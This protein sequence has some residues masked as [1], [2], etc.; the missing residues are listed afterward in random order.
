MSTKHNKLQISIDNFIFTIISYNP[1]AY[2]GRGL[3]LL[4][5][6]NT[7]TNKKN[8]L[9]LYRSN[10]DL[11]FWRLCYTKDSSDTSQFEKGSPRKLHYVMT[12]F[13]HI[14]LQIFINKKMEEGIIPINDEVADCFT[15]YSSVDGLN[16]KIYN[17]I[18]DRTGINVDYEDMGIFTND[19]FNDYFHLQERNNNTNEV[20]RRKDEYLYN[21][22]KGPFTREY[23][24]CG[25]NSYFI[26]KEII[27][28]SNFLEHNYVPGNN[29]K[30]CDYNL[31]LESKD[32]HIAIESKFFSV[33]LNKNKTTSIQIPNL[34]LYYLHI[35]NINANGLIHENIFYPAFI[36]PL[37]SRINEFGMYDEYFDIGVYICKLFDYTKRC[38]GIQCSEDYSFQKHYLEFKE[39]L[40]FPFNVI[41]D[42]KVDRTIFIK[43]YYDSLEEQKKKI[44]ESFIYIDRAIKNIEKEAFEF[45]FHPSMNVSS[46][47]TTEPE[48]RKEVKKYSSV[49]DKLNEDKEKHKNYLEEIESKLTSKPRI[50][51]GIKKKRRRINNKLKRV[52]SVKN[53]NKNKRRNGNGS[54]KRKK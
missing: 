34:R 41:Y 42:N 36:C 44:K 29:T 13:I 4:E 27:T 16:E 30:L 51:E 32:F 14:E 54:R 25:R 46:K 49:I 35:K 6:E 39:Q 18:N 17:F 10:S 26:K 1:K 8:P 31:D 53:K 9:C 38:K 52:L 50:A 19:L 23:G 12:T 20:R 40:L 24:Y 21:K 28:G 22:K 7:I 3:L 5:S 37:D 33:E 15:P 45:E 2:D 11:G 43:N 47:F 48:I